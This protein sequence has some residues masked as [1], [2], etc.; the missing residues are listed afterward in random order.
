[1][2]ESRA[3]RRGAHASLVVKA[4]RGKACRKAR[5]RRDRKPVAK[6]AGA[7]RPQACRKRTGSSHGAIVGGA[8]ALG[9]TL[10]QRAGE[11]R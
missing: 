4:V 9:R 2:P 8:A 5:R 7:P 11:V 3:A 10:G 1:M 6:R